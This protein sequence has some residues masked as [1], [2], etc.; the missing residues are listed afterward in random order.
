VICSPGFILGIVAVEFLYGLVLF[1]VM[2]TK[3]PEP[4]SSESEPPAV[5]EAPAVTTP[6]VVAQQASPPKL[7]D[8]Q[9]QAES[10]AKAKEN[11]PAPEEKVAQVTKPEPTPALS[12]ATEPAKPEPAAPAVTKPAPPPTPP[13]QPV[14]AATTASPKPDPVEEAVTAN[15]TLGPL[16]ALIDPL[17]DCR[18]QREARGVIIQIPPTPHAFDPD[19]NVADAPRA[20]MDVSGDFV[21]QVK[22]SGSIKPGPVPLPGLPFTFQAAGILVWLDSNNYLRLERASG[23]FGDR[24]QV[25]HVFVES[26]NAGRPGKGAMIRA[27]EGPIMLRVERRGGEFNCTYSSDGKT[28]LPVKQLSLSVPAK[29]NVG[30]SA[31][32][33]AP[34]PLSAHFED[35]TLTKP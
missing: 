2:S 15:H 20:L 26:R 18:V 31:T 19:R 34:R 35:F 27:R 33:A 10:K 14:A 24:G 22:V 11:P 13:Q 5:V 6:P 8:P 21:A 28:W 16:G 30:I 1:A 4:P 32:N 7:P 3:R 17:Q 12:V 9:P 25:H 23:Y 29:V